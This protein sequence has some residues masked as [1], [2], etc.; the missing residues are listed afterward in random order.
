MGTGLLHIYCGDGKG[1]STAAAGLAVRMAGYG[2]KVLFSRFLKTENSGE[3][4]VLRSLEQVK[5]VPVPK[6][7]GFFWNMTQQQKEEARRMYHE[8][9]DETQRLCMSGEYDMLVVDEFMAAYRY[10]WIPNE[11]AVSFLKNRP[12]HL[13]VVLTGRDPAQEL[14]ELADYVSEIKKVKHPFDRGVNARKGIEY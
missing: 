14:I 5:I 10:G 13:E 6:S 12:D 1:K 7:F 2:K 4:A 8:V 11:Q 9:W 3:L